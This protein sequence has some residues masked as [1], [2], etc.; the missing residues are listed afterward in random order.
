MELEKFEAELKRL[1]AM[2]EKGNKNSDGWAGRIA[3]SHHFGGYMDAKFMRHL[4]ETYGLSIADQ[5]TKIVRQGFRIPWRGLRS[6]FL[7]MGMN[8]RAVDTMLDEA[9][10][11]ERLAQEKP[12]LQSNA[13]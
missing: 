9:R 7:H 2:G 11:F 3:I 1:Y 12:F 5:V 10:E 4:H 6:E 8:E 13:E